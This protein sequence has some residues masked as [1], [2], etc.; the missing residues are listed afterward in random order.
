[1]PEFA[2]KVPE[3]EAFAGLSLPIGAGPM[4]CARYG[5]FDWKGPS[6]MLLTQKYY[7][8]SG[9]YWSV[10]A[11]R[12]FRLSASAELVPSLG[13]SRRFVRTDLTYLP[14]TEWQPSDSTA[15]F[16]MT[17]VEF[18][19]SVVVDRIG[20]FWISLERPYGMPTSTRF[21]PIGRA[22][23]ENAVAIGFGLLRRDRSA[24]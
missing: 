18:A 2:A 5:L 13:Y 21:A 14:Q 6:A 9:G 12:S 7:T 11:Q 17:S 15:R 8:S 24:R 10:A 22:N 16:T 19:V 23:G 1:M 4:L 20:L 3:Y